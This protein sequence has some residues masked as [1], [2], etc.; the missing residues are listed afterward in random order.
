MQNYKELIL[1][2]EAHKLALNLYE[3]SKSFPKEEIYGIT[4]QL[5]R[6]A[7]SIPCNVAEGCGR[8]TQKDFANF[9]QIA[10]GS[11]NETEYL[12][13]LAKDLEYLQQ[14]PYNNINERLNK[15]RA[16]NIKLLEKVRK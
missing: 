2:Q 9:L 13:Q 11:I 4:S 8:H 7:V 5:R 6:A 3:A 16:M 12:I 1:W 10:L 14:E 15:I